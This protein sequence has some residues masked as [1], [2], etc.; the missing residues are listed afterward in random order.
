MKEGWER[1]VPPMQL[2]ITQIQDMMA[3]VFPGK[4]VAAAERIGTGLSNTNYKIRLEDSA[5][6]YVLRLFRKGREIADK[7]LAIIRK[8]RQTVPVAGYLYADMTCSEFDKPWAV[9]EWKEGVLL[10]DVMQGGSEQDLIAAAASAGRILANIHK[11]TFTESGFFNGDM[12]VQDPMRMDGER[13]LVFMEQSL[14]QDPCGQWL[15]EELAQSVWSFSRTYS[16][17]LS[18][19]E[20]TPVLVHSDYNGLNILMRNGAAECEVS[21]VLDWEEAFS[22]NRYVDIANMLRYERN[23]SVFE[24]NFIR[25]YREGG[26]VL[27][28]H[29]KILSKLEDLVALCDMLTHSSLATPNRI[30]DLQRLIAETVQVTTNG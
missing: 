22:W 23:G 30:H 9:M 7:E 6:P 3:P 29:W 15:G 26:A 16:H 12:K 27:H 28:D 13:F 4:K 18:E 24:T 25:A 5:E 19:I 20:D 8:V 21:A 17:L 2:D 14:F 11:H 10:R 1:S